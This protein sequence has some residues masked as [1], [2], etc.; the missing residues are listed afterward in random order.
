MTRSNFLFNTIGA[1]L[2]CVSGLAYSGCQDHARASDTGVCEC[3][4]GY[5]LD[6]VSGSC[7]SVHASEANVLP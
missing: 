2:C 7:Q 4:T 3:E 1:V 5:V 6:N